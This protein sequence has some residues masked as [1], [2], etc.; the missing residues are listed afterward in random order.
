MSECNICC[1]KVKKLVTC[2]YCDFTACNS[3]MSRYVLESI[4]ASCMNC[5]KPW[6][7][8]MLTEK[9]GKTFMTKKYKEKREKDLLD[10]EK[11]LLPET[12][13]FA[14]AKK[15]L[16]RINKEIRELQE[17]LRELKARRSIYQMGGIPGVVPEKTATAKLNIK[18]P[19]KDC[20]GY[21]NSSTMICGVCDR[22]TCKNCHEALGNGVPLD[23]SSDHTCDP[24]T[25]E[26]VKMM[27]KDTKN[28]PKCMTGIHKIEGCDQMYCTQCHTAFSWKTGEIVIGERIHNPHYYEYMRRIGGGEAP[29]EIGDIPCGGVPHL[30]QMRQYSSCV[31]IMS[32]HRLLIHIQ[33]VEIPNYRTNRIE[34]NRDLRIKF[35]N[36]EITEKQFKMTLQ[37]REKDREKKEQIS[38]VLNTCVVVGSE[39][40]RKRTHFEQMTTEIR[41]LVNFTNDSMEKISKLFNRCNVPIIGEKNIMFK[42]KF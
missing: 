17:R 14:T 36:N 4:N 3:C 33:D 20:R 22:K 2:H 1:E 35:L 19:H 24:N 32:F 42:Q 9:F 10:T 27:M 30:S 41:E 39:M 15:E 26:T 34:G 38:Q 16:D 12:Q 8:E 11:A 37:K 6:N 18:C 40:L 21:V 25:V 5:K 23:R 13:Q 28:C 29:R 31:P 7:R